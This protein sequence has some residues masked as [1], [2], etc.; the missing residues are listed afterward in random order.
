MNVGDEYHGTEDDCLIPAQCMALSLP[1]VIW[2]HKGFPKPHADVIS[3]FL[4]NNDA[5]LA[6]R[7]EGSEGRSYSE[8]SK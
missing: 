3:L 4:M 1:L 5:V 2:D 7:Q 6:I 8:R